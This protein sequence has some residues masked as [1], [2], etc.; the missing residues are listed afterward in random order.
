MSEILMFLKFSVL[1]SFKLKDCFT[2]IHTRIGMRVNAA[3]GKAG[4]LKYLALRKTIKIFFFFCKSEWVKFL[5][6]I[7]MKSHSQ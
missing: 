6:D 7:V 2:E 1:K 4:I 5:Y 3:S